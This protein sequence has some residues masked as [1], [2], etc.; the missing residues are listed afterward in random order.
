MNRRAGQLKKSKSSWALAALPPEYAV[1]FSTLQEC[2]LRIEGFLFCFVF[3][4]LVPLR[5]QGWLME[6][7]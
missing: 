5:I 3:L 6:K 7:Q 4:E 1:H 2:I